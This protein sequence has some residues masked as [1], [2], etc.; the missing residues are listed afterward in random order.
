M[1]V[2]I[3]NAAEVKQDLYD[4][5]PSNWE[6][7]LLLGNTAQGDSPVSLWQYDDSSSATDNFA[8]GVIKPTLQGGNGRWLRRWSSAAVATS[9]AYADLSGK[10]T[11]ATVATSG[12]YNDLSDKPTIPTGSNVAFN[13]SVARTLSNSSGSTNQYTISTTKNARVNYSINVAWSVVLNT[14]TG[15]VFLEYSTNA[16]S[17]WNLV[18]QCTR[19]QASNLTSNGSDDLNLTGEV[20]ANALVRLRTTQTSCTVTYNAGQEI[21][22]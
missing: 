2:R 17:S 22:Y 11:L 10:P 7:E 14:F 1:G 19:S 16:G 6:L 8:G 4:R 5:I 9:G 12:S 15:Q 3:Y 21:L 20:P 18:N 13:N